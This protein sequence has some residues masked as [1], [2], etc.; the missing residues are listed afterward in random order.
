MK[1]RDLVVCGLFAAMTA[2]L[3]QISIPFPG[4]VPLTLQLLSISLCGVILGAKRGFISTLIYIILGAIGLPVFA[5]FSGGFQCIVGYSGGFIISFPLVAFI[6][7][8]IS[9]RTNNT[10]LVFLST[11][12]GLIVNYTTGTLMFSTVTG[13]SISASLAACVIPFV[14]IDLLKGLIAT[15]IGS[16]LKQNISIRR[17][18]N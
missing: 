6:I 11:I 2:V 18:L 3:S 8:F 12:L 1:T 4:G 9:E 16:K 13:S 10:I 7:G 15:V 5:G 14:F 17:I